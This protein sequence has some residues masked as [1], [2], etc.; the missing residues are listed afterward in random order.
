[1]SKNNFSD[2][3]GHSASVPAVDV[4]INKKP[5]RTYISKELLE[6]AQ[7]NNFPILDLII[8]EYVSNDEEI[9]FLLIISG[10]TTQGD[11]EVSFIYF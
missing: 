9:K 11:C 1:M 3:V 10:V 7:S 5:F 2:N 6:Y 4:R 8:K